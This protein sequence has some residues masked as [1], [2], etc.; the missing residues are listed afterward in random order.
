M[1]LTYLDCH[2]ITSHT[3]TRH[4]NINVRPDMTLDV[5]GGR[6]TTIQQQHK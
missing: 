1:T 3:F 6:K 2:K 4:Y 5:Y